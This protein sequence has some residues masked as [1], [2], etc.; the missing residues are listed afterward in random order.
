ML[1]ALLLPA[2]QAA[3]EAARRMQCANN[4]KQLGIAV[5]NFHDTFNC[6]PAFY[7]NPGTPD[8]GWYTARGW[9]EPSFL[10]FLLPFFEQSAVFDNI[11]DG[12]RNNPGNV[13]STRPY[14]TSKQRITSLLCP[15]DPNAQRRTSNDPTWTSY[16]GCLADLLGRKEDPLPRSWLTVGTDDGGIGMSSITDGTSNSIMRIEGL[17][18]DCSESMWAGSDGSATGGDY[19]MRIA[20][21]VTA[22]Y[23]AVP[24]NCL[25]LKGSNFQFRNSNQ[26]T[27]NGLSNQG[28]GH[29]LGTRAWECNSHT[30]GIHTL[31]PPNSPS[32]H[33]D[34]N[35]AW[36]SASS[37]HAGGV[38]VV[39]LDGSTRFVTETINTQNLD[40]AAFNNGRW[41]PP[42]N[43]RDN[44]GNTFSY[45][46]WSELGA[47]NSGATVSF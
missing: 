18:H 7:Y 8:A 28:H 29:N 23:N 9:Y 34:W 13:E 45:G 11:P 21:G 15:S 26:Q 5:H 44:A 10:V 37:L 47:I 24:N 19:R 14:I 27:L 22:Y 16:R 1:I 20:V 35:Y 6:F 12:E 38:N 40:K 33:G 17:V 4:M 41:E 25:A 3:R 42:S 39:N 30:V 2:V 43:V 32:C 46:V 31:M 36:V